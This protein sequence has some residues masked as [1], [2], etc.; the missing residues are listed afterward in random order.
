[1]LGP[2]A[3]FIAMVVQMAQTR[4]PLHMLS[5]IDRSERKRPENYE[6]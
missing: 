1:M 6:R 5:V 4:K 2:P 3:F